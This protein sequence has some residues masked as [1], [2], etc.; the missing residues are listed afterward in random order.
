MVCFCSRDIVHVIR[1][2]EENHVAAIYMSRVKLTP[3]VHVARFCLMLLLYWLL[4]DFLSVFRFWAESQNDS[5][6]L[7]L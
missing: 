3:A 7:C 1:R 5:S 6:H 4:M 2:H